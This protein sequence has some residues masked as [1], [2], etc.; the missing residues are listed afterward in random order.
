TGIES[1]ASQK[2]GTQGLD[3]DLRLEDGAI[4]GTVVGMSEQPQQIDAQVVDGTLLPGM[5][6]YMLWVADFDANKE[7]EMPAFDAQSGNSYTLKLRVVGE[8]TVTVAAGEFEAYQIEAS[9]SQ[10]SATL[11]ARKQAPHIVLRQEPAGQ[12]I[13]IELREI[14]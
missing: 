7:I 8:T 4:T 11:Y 14:R 5:D 10:G 2:M 3:I 1:H 9:G 12:P 6:D 13:V